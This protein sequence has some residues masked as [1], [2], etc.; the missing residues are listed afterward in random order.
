MGGRM[1]CNVYRFV[2]LECSKFR[3]S[4]SNT[5]FLGETDLVLGLGRSK[6]TIEEDSNLL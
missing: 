1:L 3:G 4:S 2:A 5:G 6:N